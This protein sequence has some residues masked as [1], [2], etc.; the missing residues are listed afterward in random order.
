MVQLK[1]FFTPIYRILVPALLAAHLSAC[2]TKPP[3]SDVEAVRAYE[4]INDPLEPWNRAMLQLD[5]GL[6]T[7]LFNPFIA[8]YETIV[9]EPGRQGVTNVIRNF[10]SPITLANDLLQGEGRRAG[11]TTG[12]FVVNSTIG[13]L[14]LFDVA[15]RMGLPYHSEDLGQTLAVW[16]VG[17]GPYLYVP[18]LG[19]SGTRDLTGYVADAFSSDPMAWVGYADNPFWWQ[20]AYF[21]GIAFDAKYRAG[22]VLDDL[23][24]SSID[25]YAALRAAYRQNRGR[26]IRNGAPAPLPD[27]DEFDDFDDGDG[28]PFS[29]TQPSSSDQLTFMQSTSGASQ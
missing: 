18:I 25:Y 19:P 1:T 14:G 24:A 3:A 17:E 5:Q 29:A 9:P 2:A 7:V 6:D 15:T 10:R 27:L 26:A 12:R 28:D 21:Y 8:V 13:V 16:G 20:V 11:I 4:E 23:K 22:P